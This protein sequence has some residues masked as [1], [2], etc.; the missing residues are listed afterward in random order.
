MMLPV[1]E[2]L[3]AIECSNTTKPSLEALD[4]LKES[5]N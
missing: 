2:S 1:K 3:D 5:Q 4:R